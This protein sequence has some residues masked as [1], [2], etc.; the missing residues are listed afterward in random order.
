MLASASA[1]AA[2]SGAGCRVGI[3]SLLLHLTF[4]SVL[5]AGTVNIAC[6]CRGLRLTAGVSLNDGRTEKKRARAELENTR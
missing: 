4:V 2:P 3:G 1:V 5:T 6:R